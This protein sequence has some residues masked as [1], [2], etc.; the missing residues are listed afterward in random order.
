MPVVPVLF[1]AALFVLAPLA[2]A[3]SFPDS[4][5]NVSQVVS[6]QPETLGIYLGSPSLVQLANASSNV[7]LLVASHDFFGSSL[8][9]HSVAKTFVSLD[10]GATFSASGTAPSLYWASL[11]RAGAALYLLGVSND[12]SAPSSPAAITI[13]RS[14][15]GSASWSAASALAS[16]AAHSFSTGP[17]PVLSWA[18]RLWRAFE[19]NVGSWG[20]GY[21]S[22]VLSASAGGAV[23]LTS[24]SAWTLSG[25][26]PFSA[27]AGLVPAAWANASLGVIPNYGWLEGNAVEP[28]DAADAG[29]YIML[30]VNSAPAANKAALLYVA[31]PTSAP[32]FRSWVDF[33]GGMSKFTV[34]RDR[35]GT[36]LYVTL[37]NNVVDESVSLPP[38]CGPV[39]V[40]GAPLPCCGF[41]EACAV[42]A[43]NAT[44]AWCHA[45]ARNVLTLAVAPAAAGPWRVVATILND[46][47]GVPPFLSEMLTGF[48]YVD[49]DFDA[50][51]QD[52]LLAVRASYRGANNYHNANRLLFKRVENWRNLLQ[53][54]GS[55][56]K[57]QLV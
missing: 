2:V 49:W 22:L 50:N 37:S 3:Q 33:P 28:E 29:V 36:G 16:D 10:G 23:D 57:L 6:S 5:L 18:G 35:N 11:F 53:V 32:V 48:Q 27:V 43:E 51:G 42:G 20:S 14:D 25:E 4:T 46:D 9:S 39:T 45:A 15:D 55:G 8:A 21:A 12:G 38:A 41:L 26:L 44:C 13:S 34:R 30:R 17:T 54:E 40:T 1:D 47:T 31:G 19:R 7:S 24:P 52:L 56:K